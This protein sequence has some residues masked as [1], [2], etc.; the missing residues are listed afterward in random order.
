MQIYIN[1]MQQKNLK[2]RQIK[3]EK[4][5]SNKRNKNFENELKKKRK[6]EKIVC[7]KQKRI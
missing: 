4:R 3:T 5:L 7:R 2:S 1:L 6:L